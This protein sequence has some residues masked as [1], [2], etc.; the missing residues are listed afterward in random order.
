LLDAVD[1][2]QTVAE[3]TGIDQTFGTDNVQKCLAAAIATAAAERDNG[4]AS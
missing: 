2:L 3:A 1:M 4:G